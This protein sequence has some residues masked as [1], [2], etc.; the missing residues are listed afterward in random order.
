M[1]MKYDAIVVAGGLGKRADLGQN[2]VLYK[3]KNGKTVIE[4]SCH[5]F[6]EDED[7]QKVI[8][9]IND[10]IDFDSDKVMI[11]EG[12][13]E[14]FD[15]VANGLKEV[16]AEYVLIHDGARPFLD[17]EDLESVKKEVTIHEA[18]ILAKKSTNTIKYS[19]DGFIEKTIDRNNI[20][21]A[22]TPQAFKTD[23]IK[24]VYKNLTG[25]IT[26]DAYL[27]E[28]TGRKVKLVE[29]KHK[30]CKLTSKEDFENL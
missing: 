13:K 4:T 15:S 14:R 25:V 3:M 29:S 7:C 12:G 9:V 21:E 24:E 10:D 23:L 19:K 30:N 16:S 28:K 8:L 1:F 5:L 22:E 6:I 27:V 20:Y 18:E 26:D 11:V 17:K 2:K